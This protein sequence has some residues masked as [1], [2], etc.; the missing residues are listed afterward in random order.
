[1]IPTEHYV[2]GH[3]SGNRGV[4]AAQQKVV[5]RRLEIVVLDRVRARTVPSRDRLRVLPPHLDLRDIGIDDGGLAAV[6]RDA[7][8]LPFQRIAVDI[9]AVD[10]DLLRRLRAIALRRAAVAEQDDVA[11]AVLR[12]RELEQLEAPVV[13]ARGRSQRRLAIWRLDLRQ[14]RGVRRQHSRAGLR[15]IRRVSR[16]DR[17]ELGAVLARQ[18]EIADVRHAGP[19]QDGIPRARAIDR[20]LQIGPFGHLEHLFR[21]ARLGRNHH[22]STRDG[23][24]DPGVLHLSCLKRESVTRRAARRRRPQSGPFQ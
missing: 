23:E 21:L 1:M 2:L 11:G 7:A 17:D 5:P 3:Q 13:R 10:D 12:R 20:G 8:L 19:K 15:L 14:Q 6:E 16:P 9:A 4:G 24:T 22:E 18:H